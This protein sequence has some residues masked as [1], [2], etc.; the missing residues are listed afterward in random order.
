MSLVAPGQTHFD[1][2]EISPLLYGR[3]DSD[4]YKSSLA[5]CKNWI[6]TLQGSLTRRPGTAFVGEVKD[7]SKHVRL[8]PFIYSNTQAYII[9]IGAGYIRFWADYGQVSV[10]GTPVEI[11]NPYVPEN[12]P[13]LRFTQSA[14]ILYITHP[15]WPPA[16]LE[17]LSATS[18]QLVPVQ[19]TDGPYEDTIFPL[20]G[21]FT[22][23]SG[24]GYN[25]IASAASGSIT[26]STDYAAAI[27]GA[28]SN[29]SGAIRITMTTQFLSNE[30]KYLIFGVAGTT[31]ANGLWSINIIDSSHFDLIGSTFVHAY[32]SGGNVAENLFLSPRDIGRHIRLESGNMWNWG[33][34]TAVP[35]AG[36]ATVSLFGTLAGTPNMSGQVVIDAFNL[37]AWYPF[38]YPYAV[39]FHQNRLTFTGTPKTPQRVDGSC[40][41]DY[42]NFAPS[43]IDG[44]VTDRNAIS[45]DLNANDVNALVWLSSD[46]RGLNAGSLASEWSIRASTSLVALTPTNVNAVRSTKWGSFYQPG[47]EPGIGGVFFEEDGVVFSSATPNVALVGKA[48]MFVQRGAKKLR[49]MHYYFDIDGYRAT[50]LTE[51]AEHI[52]G[53][54]IADLAP[55]TAPVPLVWM[56]RNDGALIGMVYDRD[57]LQL[58]TGWHQHVLG[59]FGDSAGNPPVIESIAVIPDPTGT[60]DDLWMV[61]RRWVNGATVRYIEYLTKVFEETDEQSEAFFLDCGNTINNPINIS[62]ITPGSTT[63]VLAP[64]HGLST[65]D[66]IRIDDVSGMTIIESDGSVVNLVN[67][68]WFIITKTDDD[69][70][71]LKDLSG[72]AINSTGYA[73]GLGGVCRKLFTSISGLT[74]LENETVSILADGAVLPNQVVSNTGTL[75]LPLNAAIVSIGYPYNSDGQTLRTEGGSRNGVAL[76]KIRRT[77]RVGVMVQ[78]SQGLLLGASFDRLDPVQFRTQGVSLN[79]RADSLFSGILTQTVEFDYDYENQLCFRVL[80]PL[81][82]VIQAILPMLETQDRM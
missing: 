36:S 66:K 43:G 3:I 42:E 60:R 65:N 68:T 39:T 27:S 64:S 29:G 21:G 18:F 17:R 44:T 58:R 56:V 53:T 34:I 28:A 69:N 6:P 5:L 38:N 12:I 40:V 63:S 61:V 7:S 76:G 15:I 49:E 55:A 8:I 54:G 33:I 19:N 46:E 57:M 9:E 45:F 30:K 10:M 1:G 26:F 32:V 79:D 48:T 23:I 74:Y 22:A 59:G 16:K 62:T 51:L 37:G 72:N 82:C 81:P 75:T 25:A 73:A 31:E 13:G 50:D 47:Q 14:D 35:T 70:F 78:R 20:G 80:Q 2:G 11:A 41:S 24:V 67:A 52:T 4:R 71:T 77:H